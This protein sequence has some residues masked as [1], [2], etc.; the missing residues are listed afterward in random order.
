MVRVC[1]WFSASPRGFS[2]GSPI[3]FPFSPKTN[4]SKFQFDPEHTDT[5]KFLATFKCSVGKQITN[6]Q[7]TCLFF[8]DWYLGYA[9]IN[10]AVWRENVIL[11][12]FDIGNADFFVKEKINN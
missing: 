5:Y 1:C 12:L 11:N 8:L 3:D 9:R 7:F 4:F 10:V 2:L 6:Y